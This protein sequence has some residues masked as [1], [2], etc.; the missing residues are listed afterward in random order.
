[1]LNQH[2]RNSLLSIDLRQ[3]GEERINLIVIEAA[4][5]FVEKEHAR[6]TRKR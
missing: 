6:R 3:Q 2:D 1:M 4:K 5:R